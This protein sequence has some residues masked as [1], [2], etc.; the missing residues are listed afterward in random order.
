MQ[1]YEEID[2]HL[3]KA[4]RLACSP[5]SYT[6]NSQATHAHLLKPNRNMTMN[7]QE[8]KQRISLMVF[9]RDLRIT[10]NPALSASLKNAKTYCLFV[11]DDSLI[12]GS[13]PPLNRLKFLKDSLEDLALSLKSIGGE[14]IIASGKWADT[15]LDVAKKI[16]ASEI[17]ITGDYS[18][19][20]TNRIINLENSCAANKI[21]LNKHPGISI[22]EPG[23]LAPTAGS[24]Y[25]IFTPYFRK[26]IN[27]SWRRQAVLPK[28]I[29]FGKTDHQFSLSQKSRDLLSISSSGYGGET[30]GSE[31]MN[32]WL[33]RSSNAYN[34]TKDV[35]YLDSTSHLSAFLHFGCISPLNLAIKAQ[36]FP[37]TENFVRQLCWRD[38][39]LQILAVRPDASINDYRNRND[40]WTKDPE[41]FIA[42]K[43]GTTGFPLVDAGMRQL[44]AEG[45]MHNRT[46]MVTASFL[47]KD[48]YLDWREGASHFMEHLIDGDIA[49]NQLGWQW[50]AGT[51]TDSNPHRILNPIR[52]SER[53]DPSGSYIQKWVPELSGLTPKTI[54]DPPSVIRQQCGYPEQIVNHHDAVELFR[55][56][57]AR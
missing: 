54:H 9:T 7:V 43:E 21:T 35:P 11:F 6:Q 51:G 42:W 4:L 57:R 45:F 1:P 41:S 12:S 20:A 39:F 8:P 31:K 46:R 48:L 32:Q 3:P 52:Q 47:V 24:E 17:N 14:L 27:A 13:R 30:S 15:V 26:W 22:V 34:S 16:H 10:D 37:E 23:V 40:I 19:Y 28:T 50:V 49:N 55:N 18:T 44:K 36:S 33:S 5:L 53:F 56:R 38:F 25:K 29:E 2:C